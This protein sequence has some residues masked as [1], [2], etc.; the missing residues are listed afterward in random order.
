MASDGTAAP[1]ILRTEKLSEDGGVTKEV[2]AEGNGDFP[3]EG[4]EVT[5]ESG[6]R[7]GGGRVK[8]CPPS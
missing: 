3:K 1:A 2:F 7:E 5:G 8:G 4:D 6:R